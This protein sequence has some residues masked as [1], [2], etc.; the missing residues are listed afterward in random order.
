MK[1]AMK[2]ALKTKRIEHYGK[3]T[4]H[5][6]GDVWK[7][8][9]NG[10]INDQESLIGLKNGYIEGLK[11]ISE[12]NVVMKHGLQVFVRKRV[13]KIYEKWPIWVI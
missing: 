12:E 11:K 3:K 7:M 8:P 2:K 9:L 5:N 6:E 1:N 13:K 10:C 4:M